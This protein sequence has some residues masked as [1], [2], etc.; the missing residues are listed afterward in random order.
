MAHKNDNPKVKVAIKLEPYKEFMP[1]KDVYKESKILENLANK[2]G[3]PT[4]HQCS[5]EDEYFVM[6]MELLG[7]TLEDLLRNCGGKFGL[8]TT[9]LLADQMLDRIQTLHS[10]KFLH[11]DL[12]PDN[13]CVGV[14]T[15]QDTIYM[16]D[17]G[18]AKRYSDP[19]TGLHIKYGKERGVT[20]TARYVSINSHLGLEQSRRDDLESL[21]YILVY[22]MRGDL[23]WMGLEAQNDREIF[24]RIKEV[25]INTP[26]DDLCAGLEGSEVF[27]EYLS[28]TRN[29]RFEEKPDYQWIRNLFRN[30]YDK[31]FDRWDNVF[32]WN[33]QH[34]T[35]LR[36]EAK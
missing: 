22:F 16:I 18:L 26:I 14:K 3:F 21:G 27:Q 5:I 33:Y 13:F 1:S 9:L 15:K 4:L 8:K 10:I 31:H 28:Y 36:R 20:G 24:E 2:P 35:L 17:Y 19:R 23:P 30:L 34:N 7:P 29:L 11:K 6:I 12:K 32:D 25:K